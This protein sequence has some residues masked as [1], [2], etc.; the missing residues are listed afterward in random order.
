M[1]KRRIQ[2]SAHS[3][4]H[5]K[6]KVIFKRVEV[7]IAMKQ[8]KFIHDAAGCNQSVDGFPNGNAMTSQ[9]SEIPRSLDGDFCVNNVYG[10]E[11]G[12]EVFGFIEIPVVLK[13]L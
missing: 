6:P 8:Y 9:D 12:E 13:T 11:R 2:G 3:V 10:L 4:S 7:F 5:P 1:C